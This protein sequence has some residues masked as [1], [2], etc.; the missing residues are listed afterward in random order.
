MKIF[1]FISLSLFFSTIAYS[2]E[3]LLLTEEYKPFQYTDKQG[4][5]AG[6][7]IELLTMIFKEAEIGFKEKKI[8]IYPWSRAYPIVLKKK[9]SAIFMTTRNKK[10]ENLFKWVGPL[11]PRT[12]WLYK[13]SKRKDIR[14]RTLEEAKKYQV[15]TY[16]AAQSDYLVELGFPN[17]DI[18]HSEKLNTT[19]LL[20]ERFD[21]MPSLELVMFARLRDLGVS[22][23][24]VEK[25]VVF[26]NRFDFYL[27]I[28]KQTSDTIVNRLQIAFDKLRE[29]GSYELLKRKYLK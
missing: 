9:N 29:N 7:G 16:K 11:Y 21:L 8:H 13:L 28:N 23:N 12:M 4:K 5:T 24:T 1:L 10:R 18:T 27:A 6:F 17:L 2:Q 14:I 3:I 19:K 15:G 26:D 22:Y 20:H 25:V